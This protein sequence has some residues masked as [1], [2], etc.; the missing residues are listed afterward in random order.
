[1]D[2]YFDRLVKRSAVL[3]NHFKKYLTIIEKN[4]DSLM[5][6]LEN[7]GMK[8]RVHLW[9]NSPD[10]RKE[11]QTILLVG[12][13]QQERLNDLGCYFALQFLQMNLSALDDIALAVTSDEN[14][15]VIYKEFMLQVG[16]DFRKLTATY[17][18]QLMHL[19][20]PENQ[21]I[22][23]VFLGVGTRSDQD[24]IDVGV[25]D[26]G[27]EDREILNKAICKLNGEMFKKAIHLHFHLSEHVGNPSSYSA[28]LEEYI[29][30]LEHE[31]HD[32]VIITEMI[33]AA[34]ITG[35]RKLFSEFFRK[36]ISRYFYRRNDGQDLKYHEG[37]LRGIVGEARSFMF[38]EL[39]NDRI[40]PKNDGLRMIKGGLF[41]AKTIFN[42]RQV[43][44]WA[45]IE[46][47]CSRDKR[48][49]SQYQKVDD[50]LTF[51]EIF[52][53]LYQLLI[54]EE[55]EIFL[56]DASARK[57]LGVV[58]KF[59]GYR[60]IGGAKATDFLLTDYYAK[61]IQAK[62]TIKELLPFA[63]RH[64]ES[65]SILGKILRHKKVTAEG[66]RRIG[67]L[68]IRFLESTKFF[69]GTRFW[70]D[71]IT[72]LE[73][74]E[75]RVLKRFVSDLCALT[76][77]ERKHVLNQFVEWG[78]N[79]FITMFSFINLLHKYKSILP[80]CHLFAELN[81]LFF[82]RV[83][84]TEEEAQRLSVVFTHYP[85]LVYEYSKI[86]TEKQQKKFYNWLS[87][88]VWDTEVLPARDCLRYMLKLH[89]SLSKYFKR[90]MHSVLS[91]KPEYI[92]YL[93]DREHLEL[94]GKGTLAKIERTNGLK[95]KL[96]NLK[97]YHDFQLFRMALETLAG[98]STI[99]LALQYTEFSDKYIRLLFDT[100]K[101]EIDEKRKNAVETGDMLGIFVTG[102]HGQMQAF[103]DDYDLIILLN[104][105]DEEMISYCSSIVQRMHREIIKSGVLPHYNLA[106]CT[107][108][109][110]CTFSKLE[111]ILSKNMDDRFILKSQLVGARLVVGSSLLL[112]IFER[113]ILEPFIFKKKNKFIKDMLK[114]IATRR[115]SRKA[116]ADS[117]NL[118]E[119]AG[120]LR[121]IENLM[122]ILRVLF[123][124][125]EHSNFRFLVKLQAN[126]PAYES[127]F[128]MLLRS[129]DFLRKIRNLHRITVTANNSIHLNHL[130]NIVEH[131]EVKSKRQL[132]PSEVLFL[133]VKMSM[134]VSERV[135]NKIINEVIITRLQKRNE[136]KTGEQ[137]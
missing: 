49:K 60:D 30:L 78:W 32:F 77:D 89:Y 12:T 112:D 122:A 69:R 4:L 21:P 75:G 52:R 44:A 61:V 31:I 90:I 38:R 14:K 24:D 85:Q 63:M 42:L 132:N 82:K 53:Y 71:I 94:I 59:M 113:D 87:S 111:I 70:D 39:S 125:K 134:K 115:K 99:N 102:G 17:M 64:L 130:D 131:L 33:G 62:E 107:K 133:R 80:E 104:S 13:S 114:E 29:D 109:Y 51:L 20:L 73:R 26:S 50:S 121:D 92:K 88:N 103:D 116:K 23:Y 7:A 25:V 48:R 28:S 117:I 93:I 98:A 55:E 106:Q 35:S 105:E 15:H 136:K 1:M 101:R 5:E 135:S 129:Y 79:S 84:G 43:N 95:Q 127:H 8:E 118:K 66:E 37:Y 45:I 100:C 58:A 108:S 72:A 57:N 40:N 67:N 27:S 68:G 76:G 34:R 91:E 137:N 123:K 6:R 97:F 3:G 74:K 124:A 119:D 11:M 9:V 2:I 120:G 18:E 86:L 46:E 47:L 83:R 36:V 54:A 128:R 126:L 41:A 10:Y 65:I 16:H 22:E 110:V 19:F 96:Q 56:T 81:K